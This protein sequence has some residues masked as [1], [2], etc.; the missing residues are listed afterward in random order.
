V[1]DVWKYV[2]VQVPGWF[3]AAGV[4]AWLVREFG[5]GPCL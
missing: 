1:S 2:L 3:L 5:L 4:V